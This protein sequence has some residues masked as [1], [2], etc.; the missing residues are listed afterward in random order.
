MILVNLLIMKI[1]HYFDTYFTD[2][3]YPHS[4]NFLNFQPFQLK[5]LKWNKPL[6]S[7]ISLIARLSEVTTR[8]NFNHSP[9]NPANHPKS[10]LIA[11]PMPKLWT[12]L[13]PNT[14]IFPSGSSKRKA[15]LTLCIATMSLNS[16]PY[17]RYATKTP[18]RPT[19]NT[20][21]QCTSNKYPPSAICPQLSETSYSNI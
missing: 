11:T 14:T 20:S 6:A 15:S 21:S 5:L 16:C 3:L 4:F 2:I 10:P 13:N 1:F 9:S 8:T 18:G 7:S 19:K 12:S 17:P